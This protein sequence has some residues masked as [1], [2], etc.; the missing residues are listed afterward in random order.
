MDLLKTTGVRRQK[1]AYMTQT[2]ICPTHKCEAPSCQQTPAKKHSVWLLYMCAQRPLLSLQGH[3]RNRANTVEVQDGQQRTSVY[4]ATRHSSAYQAPSEKK[5]SLRSTQ[6]SELEPQM[7]A[8]DHQGN[9]RCNRHTI[10]KPADIS[11]LGCS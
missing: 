10:L 6:P 9:Y 1:C 4:A 2:C 5:H 3:T 8:W 11:Q 7:H